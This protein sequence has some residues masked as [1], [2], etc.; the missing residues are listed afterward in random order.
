M[1]EREEMRRV[2]AEAEIE[3]STPSRWCTHNT[4]R[5]SHTQ[6][7]LPSQFAKSGPSRN[8]FRN[9]TAN[10]GQPT[11]PLNAIIIGDERRKKHENHRLRMKQI[12]KFY[13]GQCL[14]SVYTISP[15][16]K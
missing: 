1:E 6:K 8:T 15:K 11:P 14:H 5:N 10:H 9:F 16:V 12:R 4:T 3:I 7:P 2:N 13:S